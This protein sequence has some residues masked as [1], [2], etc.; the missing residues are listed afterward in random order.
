MVKVQV[1]QSGCLVISDE[2]DGMDLVTALA[3]ESLLSGLNIYPNPV[4]DKVTVELNTE[5][6]NKSDLILKVFN[7]DGKVVTDIDFSPTTGEHIIDF[8]NFKRGIYLIVIS[9]GEVSV[10]RKLVKK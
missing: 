7:N 5:F 8:S 1:E 3:E 10:Q 6:F 2:F 4:L 9:D